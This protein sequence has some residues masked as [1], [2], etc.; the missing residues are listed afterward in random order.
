MTAQLLDF[1]LKV[2]R[3]DLEKLNEVSMTYQPQN[4]TCLFEWSQM[5]I[6]IHPRETCS[7]WKNY[8]F[9]FLFSTLG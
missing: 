3:M 4:Y 6:L 9:F 8:V 7:N 1:H 5:V 2:M